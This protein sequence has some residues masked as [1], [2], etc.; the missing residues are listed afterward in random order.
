MARGGLHYIAPAASRD[1]HGAMA[2]DWYYAHNALSRGKH[3][4]SGSV[5]E[6]LSYEGPHYCAPKL[7]PCNIGNAR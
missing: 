7:I 3:F 1:A 5:R 2:L 6:E 4:G